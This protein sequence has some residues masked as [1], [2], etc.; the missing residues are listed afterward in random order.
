MR[1]PPASP[2]SRSRLSGRWPCPTPNFP[3]RNRASPPPTSGLDLV[4]VYAAERMRAVGACQHL[5]PETAV[6]PRQV[7]AVAV[8]FVGQLQAVQL[9]E[10]GDG[11]GGVQM[12][13]DV[14]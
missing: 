2:C 1:S 8:V 12:V 7:R 6:V 14:V 3:L 11:H 9:A 4:P 5:V 10:L 13:L